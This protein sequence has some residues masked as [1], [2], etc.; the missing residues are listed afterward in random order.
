M[1]NYTLCY[2]DDDDLDQIIKLWN[3]CFGDSEDFIREFFAVTQLLKTTVILKQNGSVRSM[4]ISFD[5]LILCGESASYIYA[6]CTDPDSRSKGFG[7]AVLNETIAQAKNRGAE[8]VFLR[9]AN[10]ELAKGYIEGFCAKS[11]RY[12][13]RERFFPSS[14]ED[15]AI[16]EI[17][18][19][20]YASLCQSAMPGPL[21]KA[22]EIL[23]RHYGGSF[24]QI[25]DCVVQTALQ[26]GEWVIKGSCAPLQYSE[27]VFS[28]LC[29]HL[30][31]DSIIIESERHSANAALYPSLVYFSAHEI[32]ID[33]DD[34]SSF[35]YLN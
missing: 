27:K 10:A 26:G 15:I 29:K 2:A 20:S 21:I 28:S 19:A 11:L 34:L 23:N 17:T 31:I 14:A 35:F 9:P 4:M 25:G 32:N 18:A 7:T 1:K 16:I 12:V 5:G 30:G 8:I 13:M 6:L 3:G 22:Q 24:F 33:L